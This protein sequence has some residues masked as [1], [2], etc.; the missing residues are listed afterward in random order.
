MIG[1]LEVGGAVWA[2]SLNHVAKLHQY[3]LDSGSYPKLEQRSLLIASLR[4]FSHCQP[5]TII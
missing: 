3:N 4:Q 5:E 2:L 1:I